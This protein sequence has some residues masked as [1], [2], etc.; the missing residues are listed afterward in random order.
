M[1]LIQA[2]I[3]G[4]RLGGRVREV[5]TTEEPDIVCLQEVIDIKGGEA[6]MF[7]SLEELKEGTHLTHS[8]MSPVFSLQ[9]MRR[10][11]AF[12]NA[13]LSKHSF[14]KT[15]TIFTRLE[16][17]DNFDILEDDDYN[18]RNLQHVIIELNGKTLH[19]LNH[20]G[21]HIHQHKNG[22]DETMRQCKLI[23]DYV[24]KL[25]GAVILTG[26]FNLAPH[27]ESLEQLNDVLRNLSIEYK[28]KTTRN[29]LTYKT[30]VCDFIF[31]NDKVKVNAF[32]ASDKLISDH[33]ALVLEFE[34]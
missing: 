16:H 34:L 2:N 12:G 30:E 13:I 7:A 9:Y 4:G 6:M 1:K 31:V 14:T 26:D 17:M 33:K 32:E 23:A 5:L 21:H 29:E 15:E 10:K 19:V 20:H 28:L 22:D 8:Y 18:I 24:S 27:S 3:W 25:E 11:A